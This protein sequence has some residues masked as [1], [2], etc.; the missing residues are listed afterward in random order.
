MPRQKAMSHRAA[1][2]IAGDIA[3]DTASPGAQQNQVDVQVPVCRQQRGG[4]HHGFAGHKQPGAF[5]GNETDQNRVAIGVEQMLERVD[6][7]TGRRR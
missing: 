1:D 4:Y 7:A 2:E 6:Q 3:N 5:Q